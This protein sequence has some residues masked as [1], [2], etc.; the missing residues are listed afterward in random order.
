MPWYLHGTGARLKLQGGGDGLHFTE[1]QVRQ[2]CMPIERNEQSRA[3]NGVLAEWTVYNG[4][5]VQP[6]TVR[7]LGIS[8]E[9]LG[10]TLISISMREDQVDLAFILP[11]SM[12]ES[13]FEAM[14][15]V[16][17]SRDLEYMIRFPFDFFPTQDPGPV[18]DMREGRLIAWT[19][20]DFYF[21]VQRSGLME[22]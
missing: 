12:F 22:E 9:K 19:G 17:K 18:W 4:A 16:I 21:R 15:L 8:M 2:H 1:D 14:R 20:T 7:R 13:F 11:S 6:D 10:R 5:V 3:V